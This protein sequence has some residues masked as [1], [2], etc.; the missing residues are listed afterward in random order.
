MTVADAMFTTG[1]RRGPGV[2]VNGT[3]PG[4]LLRLKEGQ[5]LVVDLVNDSSM[6][7]SIHWH[8]L[9]VPF[10]MDGVPGVTMAAVEPGERFRYE[11]PIRQAGT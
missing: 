8:G 4:P 5:N 7:T 10:L 11:F 6:G 1:T 3:I 9:L 2:T